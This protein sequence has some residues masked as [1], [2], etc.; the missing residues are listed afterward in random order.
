VAWLCDEDKQGRVLA[1][2][3]IRN[4]V[5]PVR[6][7]LASAVREGLLRSNP[8]REVD[9]PHRPTADDLEGEDVKVMSSE[10]LSTMLG[11]VSDKW[12]LFFRLLAATGLR[13]SE[14]IALQWRHMA[15]DGRR[16]HVK[17]RRALV[18]G[19][20]GPPKTRYGHRDVPI[21]VELA[22]A[23]K[24]ARHAST[25]SSDED[26]VFPSAV[27]SYLDQP[28][29]RKRVLQPAGKKAGLPWVGFHAF[30]HTCASMLFA[31]G[32]N[33]VQVQRWLGHHSPAFTLATYVHLLDGDL[34]EPLEIG[35][36]SS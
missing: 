36:G 18:K 4:V 12:R 35:V 31:Q 23:L 3:T 22:A 8:A 20:M 26:P 19:R 24:A 21:S 30:R 17:V 34:G 6:A 11:S 14:A 5:V 16:P 29:L 1:D 13:I 33:A 7:C 10:E 27:G 25:W 2:Q 32:R 28:K 9:L 15:L